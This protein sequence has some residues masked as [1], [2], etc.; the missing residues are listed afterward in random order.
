M[1]SLWDYSSGDKGSWGY[2]PGNPWYGYRSDKL[3]CNSLKNQDD[4]WGFQQDTLNL[5]AEDI[6][7]LM[8]QVLLL[9]KET[10]TM[11]KALSVWDFMDDVDKV[12]PILFHTIYDR[13]AYLVFEDELGPEL[14]ETMLNAWDYWPE[15]L[16]KM[17]IEGSSPWFD[18][19]KTENKKETRNDL[20]LR[21]AIEAASELETK[22]GD[23]P[24][25]W[26][27]GRVHK[28]EFV[29]P[30]RRSGFGKGLAGGGVLSFPGSADT[31]CRGMY[32]Y[33]NPY[34]VTVSASLRMV[35]DLG[36]EDKVMAVLPG[37]VSGRLFHPHTKDQIDSFVKGE[38]VFWWFSDKAINE[39]ATSILELNP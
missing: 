13:F 22:I 30:I 2:D 14:T 1:V 38:K 3:L 16:N 10:E 11:G 9:N 36:D 6:A 20:F 17:I 29:S 35:A 26:K 33:N 25:E 8:T 5:M 21:A 39:H 15:R 24:E 19:I 37:G 12:G 7:P 28:I 31:L 32:E 4:H 27:W 34:N 23:N 18:N